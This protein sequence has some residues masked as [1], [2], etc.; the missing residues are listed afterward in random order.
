MDIFLS[1]HLAPIT[2]SLL[3]LPKIE[4]SLYT[5]CSEVILCFREADPN[6]MYSGVLH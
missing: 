4:L 2:C 1:S 3:S 6:I 5:L